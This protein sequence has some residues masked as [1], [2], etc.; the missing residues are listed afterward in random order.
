MADPLSII[1]SIIAI[2]GATDSVGKALSK[3]VIP[4]STS[5]ELLALINE[6]SDFKVV[7]YDVERNFRDPPPNHIA[8]LAD[9][10]S[11]LATL[12]NR[13]K[14]T[15]LKLEEMIE[16]KFKRAEVKDGPYKVSRIEWLRAKLE[17]ERLRKTLRDIRQNIQLHMALIY[18]YVP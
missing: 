15:I 8:V 13:G 7:L 5:D 9:Q 1:A 17:V 10:Y 2:L 3:I 12:I 18:A 4:N 14:G 16:Y 6:I 11:H